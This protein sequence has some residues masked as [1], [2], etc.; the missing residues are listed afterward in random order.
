MTRFLFVTWPGAGNQGPGIGVATALR[1]T[2]HQVAFAGYA[3]QAERFESLGFAFRVLSV[4]DRLWPVRPPQDWMPVLVDTV[5]ACRE[6][7]DDL[8]QLLANEPAD[9]LVVDCLMF[10]ALTAAEHTGAPTA[11]LVHSAP[12]AML[13]PGGPFEQLLLPAV[14][15]LRATVDRPRLK[16]LWDAWAPFPA[17]CASV[18][19]LDPLA[20][21]LPKE[22]TFLGPV[23]EPTEPSGW[24]PPWPAD[25]PRPLIVASFSTGPAWDQTSRV[26][27]TLDA[28]DD[29]RHR[30][31]VTAGMVDPQRIRLPGDAAVVPFLPHAEVFP[32]AAA[33]VTHAGHGTVVAAM[34]HGV[35]VIA[36]PNPAA[37]QP[38]LAAHLADQ[39]AGIALDGERATPAEI[40]A[41]VDKVVNDNTFRDAAATLATAIAAAPGAALAAGLLSELQWMSHEVRLH[42]SSCGAG[43]QSE[44]SHLD[45]IVGADLANSSSDKPD[46][47]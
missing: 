38:V 34:R 12:G 2:G 26:Q 13:P 30:L 39:G 17:L 25:D 15:A 6:H 3:A 7:F 41:A 32:D 14:N 9:V 47:E 11:V 24:T 8:P 31:L 43:E 4:A 18:P 21:R 10:G 40:R 27:R 37:D 16:R 35:P 33:V 20:G 42:R 46:A 28:L 22:F 19:E 1:A 45:A 36:L 5:W 44:P 23:D 29:G